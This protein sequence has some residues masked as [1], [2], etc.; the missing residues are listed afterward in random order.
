MQVDR[1]IDNVVARFIGTK[2]ERDVKRIQPLV[3]ATK[4]AT[5]DVARKKN[6]I[7]VVDRADVLSGGMDITADVQSELSK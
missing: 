4:T 5:A 1:L 3:D 7:L 6:L 2:H